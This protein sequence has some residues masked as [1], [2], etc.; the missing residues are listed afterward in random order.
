[1]KWKYL[2]KC[3]YSHKREILAHFIENMKT[4][5]YSLKIR[6]LVHFIKKSKDFLYPLRN[7]NPSTFYKKSVFFI[8]SKR[9]ISKK[10][11]IS[12]IKTGISKILLYLLKIGIF[13]NS[14]NI[15]LYIFILKKSCVGQLAIKHQSL[16]ICEAVFY[17]QKL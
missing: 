7:R 1:M 15:V 2:K 12:F 13:K 5:L 17:I 3:I 11:F 6:N 10:I 4:F 8:F 16:F 14:L 9:Q